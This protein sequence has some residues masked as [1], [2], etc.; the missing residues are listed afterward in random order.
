MMIEAGL[1]LGT[2]LGDRLGNLRAAA[3]HIAALP[4]TTLIARSG[5]Y[6]TAPVGV[7]PEYRHLAYLNAVL[8]IATG[9][10]PDALSGHIHA[11]ETLMGRVR[12]TDRFA[13]RVIDIDILYAGDQILDDDA[14]T[15]PHP[16]WSQRRFV[17]QPLA[18]VRPD[19]ILPRAGQSVASLL[20]RHTGSDAVTPYPESW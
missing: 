15:L 11:I 17:M 5:I 1:S 2:N 13:P 4:H 9:L 19:L 7:R 3:T 20:A 12:T 14:L 10:T 18:D 8:I 16:R 6:E